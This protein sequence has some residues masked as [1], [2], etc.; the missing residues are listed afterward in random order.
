M[1][2][3]VFMPADQG[4]RIAE[5]GV[6]EVPMTSA[7]AHLTE[8]IRGVRYG[9]RISAFT[10]RGERSAYVVP[11]DF[12]DKATRNARIVLELIAVAEQIP[13]DQIDQP[14]ARDLQRLRNEIL[15]GT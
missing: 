5:D 13:E 6:P 3:T 11:P 4:I 8:F 15:H 7:R 9:E 10:E 14:W 1:T 2:Y 12:M